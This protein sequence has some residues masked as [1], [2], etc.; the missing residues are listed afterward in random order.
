MVPPPVPSFF[1]IRLVLIIVLVIILFFLTGL[2]HRAFAAWPGE[3]Q[4]V[5]EDPTYGLDICNYG[6]SVT[7]TTSYTGMEVTFDG[8]VWSYP[9]SSL[10][11]GT[12]SYRMRSLNVILYYY[13]SGSWHS[14]A[15]LSY[16]VTAWIPADK[17]TVPT[18][19]IESGPF[20]PAAVQALS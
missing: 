5:R 9:Q 3:C 7:P 8:S 13:E 20:L 18:G 2:V 11:A 6:V 1:K 14:K 15:Q 16:S 10:P 19:S 12:V 4:F 17:C